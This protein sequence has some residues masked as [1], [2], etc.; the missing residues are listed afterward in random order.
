MD[1]CEDAT[2]LKLGPVVKMLVKMLSALVPGLVSGLF[3]CVIRRSNLGEFSSEARPGRKS[4]DTPSR[5]SLR[6]PRLS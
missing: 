2:V 1:C 4:G 6:L 5:A 3:E